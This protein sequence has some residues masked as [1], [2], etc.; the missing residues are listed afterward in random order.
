VLVN[1]EEESVLVLR[2]KVFLGQDV[3]WGVG[4]QVKV[5][6]S[7]GILTRARFEPLGP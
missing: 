4:V 2:R 7:L 5:I 3:S 1:K 6:G